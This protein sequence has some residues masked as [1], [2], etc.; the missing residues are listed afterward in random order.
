MIDPNGVGMSA[1]AH[2][3]KQFLPKYAGQEKVDQLIKEG[4][5]D[6]WVSFFKAKNA[7]HQN[8]D[9]PV[10][11]PWKTVQPNDTPL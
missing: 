4:G 1:P 3:L 7:W 10:I 5:F 8:P 9:L 11:T 2:Y 6:G